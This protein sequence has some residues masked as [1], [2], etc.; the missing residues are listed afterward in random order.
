MVRFNGLQLLKETLMCGR[1]CGICK[2][3]MSCFCADSQSQCCGEKKLADL[4]DLMKFQKYYNS[5]MIQDVK[6]PYQLKIIIMETLLSKDLSHLERIDQPK[7][8]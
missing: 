4:K 3:K 7:I 1:Y 5:C 8:D 2:L 6:L